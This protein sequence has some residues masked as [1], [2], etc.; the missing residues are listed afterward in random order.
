MSSGRDISRRLQEIAPP[1]GF[2][3]IE[4]YRRKFLVQHPH[5]DR[6]VFVM[7]PFSPPA[8]EAIFESVE[9]EL[10]DHGLIALRADRKAFSPI[11]WWKV[12]TYMLGSSYGIGTYEPCGIP[13]NPNV[14]IEAGFMLAL[15][16]PVLFL[17]NEELRGLPVDFSGHIF[18]T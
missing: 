6:N 15:D 14:S 17:V 5:F 12:V 7:M 16:R 11:L 3:Y 9:Q 13:F 8:S 1:A 2:E 18:K 10:D 4:P